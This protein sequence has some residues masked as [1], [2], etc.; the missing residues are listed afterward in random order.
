MN[1]RI[2]TYF[3]KLEEQVNQQDRGLSQQKRKIK[4]IMILA[5]L[6]ILY[7]LSFVQ[8]P[9]SLHHHEL[10]IGTSKMSRDTI[11]SDSTRQPP[12]LFALPVDS[13]EQLLNQHIHEKAN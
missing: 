1:K 5:S 8:T 13:F 9:L 12:S 7:V 3:N 4:W 2:K 10:S 11:V 6:F